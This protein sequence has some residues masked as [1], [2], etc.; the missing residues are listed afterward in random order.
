MLR[1]RHHAPLAAA[2]G[3]SAIAA[4]LV[5]C[6]SGPGTRTDPPASASSAAQADDVISD[7]A[8]GISAAGV[9]T[10]IDVPAQSTEEQYAQACLTAKEWMDAKGGDPNAL[11]EPYLEKV[12]ASTETGRAAFQKTWPELSTAQQAAVII[13]VQAAADGG[14]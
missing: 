3:V 2:V 12:Q 7:Q 13:A 4:V 5:G 6:S 14:C 1:T 11:I 8:I 9:T 10:R